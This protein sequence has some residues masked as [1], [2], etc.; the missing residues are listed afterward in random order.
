MDHLVFA[1]P[2]LDDGVRYVEDLLGVKTSPGG[3]HHGLGTRNRL[4]GFGP[5]TYMEVVSLDPDQPEPEKRR[6]FG[7]DSLQES[8]LVSW[9]AKGADLTALVARGRATGID[10]GD[11]VAGGRTR[12]DG[13]RL[14]WIFTDPWAERAGG[15][16]PFF[17]DWGTSEHPGSALPSLCSL[18]GLRVEHPDPDQ[19]GNWLRALGLDTPVSAGDAPRVIATLDTPNGVVELT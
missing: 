3:Q 8:R 1:A 18:I 15:V 12:P 17:I 9:C 11:P 5:D 19:V 2:D 7:L 16:V 14:D 13:T 6:W 4:I 10:L